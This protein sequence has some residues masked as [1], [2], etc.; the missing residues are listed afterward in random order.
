MSL[1]VDAGNAAFTNDLDGNPPQMTGFA[2]RIAINSDVLDDNSL[3]VQ[4]VAGQTKDDAARPNFI[5]DQLES[6]QF[7]SGDPATSKGRFQLN[8]NLGD[9]IGQVITFQGTNTQ[10][11][12]TQSSDRQ[13]TLNTIIQQMDSEYGV[14]VDDE[15][16]RLMELQNSYAANAQVVGVVKEL[17]DALFNAV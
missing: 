6:M 4:S 2:G 14:D 17:L 15:M 3:L 13:L 5:I 9:V 1:F 7:V 10:S 11:T 8:G 16:A 12:I